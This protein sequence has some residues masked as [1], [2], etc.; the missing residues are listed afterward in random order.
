VVVR[1][2]DRQNLLRQA[3]T[4][5]VDQSYPRLEAVVVS[6][7]GQD[8]AG[9]VE[10]FKKDLSI[11]YLRLESG[12]GRAGAANV[13]LRQAGGKYLC[14][15]DDDDLFYPNHVAKLIF[16][17]EETGKDFAYSD[18]EQGSY[19]LEGKN[20]IPLK[21]KHLCNGVDF[22]R[23]RLHFQNFIPSLCAMFTADLWRQAGPLDESLDYLEDWDLW[24]RMAA[25]TDLT[26]LPGITAE[27]RLLEKPRYDYHR[28]EAVI[29]HKHGP[30][31]GSSGSLL[32]PPSLLANYWARRWLSRRLQWGLKRLYRSW[33]GRAG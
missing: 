22:N 17:L 9:V 16:Y 1:T 10:V 25:L 18:C 4:S 23:D 7:G 24:L 26:R 14:L 11:Q 21:S 32:W 15:L 28:W 27:Y 19:R 5:L 33:T 13:G 6:D 12:R 31:P 2:K 30:P 29:H 8:V 20:L 3:L